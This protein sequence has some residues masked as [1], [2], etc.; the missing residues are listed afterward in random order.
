M[1]LLYLNVKGFLL[2]QLVLQINE[3]NYDQIIW[4]LNI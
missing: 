2:K 4:G 1:H 3:K